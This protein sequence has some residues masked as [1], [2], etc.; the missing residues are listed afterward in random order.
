MILYN[1]PCLSGGADE[2]EK[3]SLSSLRMPFQAMPQ[4]EKA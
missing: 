1:A 4:G 3:A 2:N